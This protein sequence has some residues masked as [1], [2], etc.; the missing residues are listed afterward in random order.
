MPTK[1]LN[2][3]AEYNRGYVEGYRLGQADTIKKLKAEIKTK[4]ENTPT[5]NDFAIC[6]RVGLE[7][8]L[9]VLDSIEKGD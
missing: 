7:T 6:K 1:S 3:R 8:A 5:D 2:E 4:I 9:E